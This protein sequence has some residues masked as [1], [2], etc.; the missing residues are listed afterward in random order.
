LNREIVVLDY[1]I[2]KSNYQKKGGE[3]CLYLQIT[4]NDIKHVV[5][6]GYTSLMEMIEKVDKKDFPFTTVI[7]KQNE[8]P[9][10]T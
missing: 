6:T 1:R 8:R 9:E 3:R 2:E 7:V 10:F 4:I 5:F